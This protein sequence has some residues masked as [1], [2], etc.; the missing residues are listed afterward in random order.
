MRSFDSDSYSSYSYSD[1]GSRSGTPSSQGEYSEVYT[2]DL[3]RNTPERSDRSEEYSSS[4]TDSYSSYSYTTSYS[5]TG[6]RSY[7]DDIYNPRNDRNNPFRRNLNADFGEDRFELLE[8]EKEEGGNTEVTSFT[9]PIHLRPISQYSRDDNNNPVFRCQ[10]CPHVGGHDTNINNYIRRAQ[11]NAFIG[12]GL[13]EQR[14]EEI[15]EKVRNDMRG[16]IR[17]L[18]GTV[19]ELRG[20]IRN[21][22]EN[23]ERWRGEME[24]KEGVRRK[25]RDEL[26]RIDR[27]VASINSI[28][29][30]EL[31]RSM[32]DEVQSF[33]NLYDTFRL[34]DTIEN[35]R[36][37]VQERIMKIRESLVEAKLCKDCVMN[38]PAFGSDEEVLAYERLIA[39]GDIIRYGNQN[40]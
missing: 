29:N 34:R 4:Y 22:N 16:K 11:N 33:F 6:G 15:V 37:G 18:L 32:E 9:C 13:N 23:L 25:I 10:R 30:E 39:S 36:R 35:T 31:R 7:S 24:Q 5:I 3:P 1:E 19:E 26:D 38:F 21:N 27:E 40:I 14:K 8:E 12:A 28:R 20:W 17:E 2:R